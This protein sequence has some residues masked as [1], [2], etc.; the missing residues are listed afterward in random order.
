MLAVCPSPG[1][2]RGLTWVR[3]GVLA[4]SL[5]CVVSNPVYATPAEGLQTSDESPDGLGPS[6][7]YE[8][9]RDAEVSHVGQIRDGRVRLDRFEIEL[10]D[11]H[12]YLAP[13]VGET[14]PALVFLG[15]GVLRGYPPDAVEHHQLHKLSD[16]HSVEE[17]FDRLVV[18]SVGELPNHIRALVTPPPDDADDGD[19][20]TANRL[21]ENR[22]ENRLE[23]QLSN[24]E[25]R[26]LEDLLQ[27]D[28]GTLAPDNTYA[29]VDIDSK[30]HGWLTVELEPHQPEEVWLYRYDRRRVTDTW[31]HVQRVADYPPDRAA[32]ALDGFAVAPES[33]RE[34]VDDDDITGAMLALPARPHRPDRGRTP[35]LSAPRADVDLAI[36]SDGNTAGT[37][38]LLFEPLEPTRGLRLRISST[39]EVTDVRWRLQGD[40]TL[41]TALVDRPDPN[42]NVTPAPDQ[43][44]ALAGEQLH[45]VQERHSRRFDVDRFEPWVTVTLPR[46]AAAGER[47][48][49]EVAY[50]GELIERHRQTLDFLLKDTLYWRPRHPDAAYSVL[51]L[52]FR[53][54]ERYRVASGGTLVGERLDG[55]T[56]IMRWA[57][58]E[59]VR[60]MSFHYGEFDVTEVERDGLPIVSVYANDNHLGFS[61]GSREKTIDDLVGAI[62]FYSDYFGPY[63]YDSLLVSE[64]QTESGQAFP[65]L[66]LLSYQAFGELHTGESELFRAHEVA[67]Q[68]WG[69]GIGW[70]GY[71]DQWMTE[72]FAHY[73][74]ALFTLHGLD[75]PDQFA[76]MLNAWRLDVLGEGHVGQGVGVHYGF[77][78]DIL[79]RSDAHE[80]GPLVVGFRLNTADTPFDYRVVVYEKGAYILHMLRSMLLDPETGDDARFSALMR[81]Y[82]AAHVGG[83]MSTQ[84][85]ETA[86]TEAFGEPMDWFFDQWVYGVEVPTYRPDLKVTPLIDSPTPFVLS[87]RIRQE[88]VSDGFKMPVPIRFTFDEHPP[89]TQRVWVD[90]AD[91]L[92]ALPLPAKP[93]RVE[94]NADGGVLAKVR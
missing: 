67:H 53:V 88:D 2:D 64:T 24:P 38:A 44:A 77:R 39:L 21:L 46:T 30:D 28:A 86:V 91:V 93:T 74:A 85:F 27:R 57:T 58:E 35:R 34:S 8:A 36:D 12:L 73:S 47:F 33:L 23:Q 32:S 13:P 48:I 1:A 15:D 75:A 82:V 72:G 14:P 26:V 84:S 92:V 40:D 4:W 20:E 10:T 80:S 5:A 63:P 3:S 59:P 78:P 19:T 87:G 71:R 90:A 18:W 50:E 6:P 22:R 31:M 49:L 9:L 89:M 69:A 76:A 17:A 45:F 25:S 42:G 68:W 94:F 66:V 7:R 29:L 61:P 62:E 54:P 65:G 43:P 41:Q 79:R 83:V 52:T 11:G 56:R 55:D 60:S 37:A 81:N 51:D 70:A 16:E